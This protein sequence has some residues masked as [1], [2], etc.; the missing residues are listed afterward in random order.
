MPQPPTKILFLN[1]VSQMSGAEA[2]LLELVQALDPA[3]FAATVALPGPGPLADALAARG[4]PVPFLPLRRIH[5]TANPLTAAAS[6]WHLVRGA[7]ALR[8]LVRRDG[9][10]LVHANSNT[11]FLYAA[12]TPLPPDVRRVW[13]SRDLVPLGRPGS[14]LC[15]RA[16][17]V[18][19]NSDAVRQQLLAHTSD[20]RHIITI[21]NGIDVARFTPQG[22]RQRR[23][24]ELGVDN[25]APLIGM[26][27]QFVPWKRQD[28][29]L[30][31]AELLAAQLP[32]ARFV[33]VGAD[34]FSDHP[35]YA[36]ELSRRADSASLAGR[37]RILEPRPDIRPLYEALDILVHPAAR[38]PFG[39]VVAEA[40]AMGKPVVAINAAG[41]AEIIRDGVD[42]L[43]VPADSAPAL[44]ASVLRLV[45]NVALRQALG[46]AARQRICDA[47][48]LDRLA[49]TVM[50]L[51][52][53]LLS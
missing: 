24:A 29:F 21:H 26:V 13:H 37:V 18:V 3:R 36:R 10:R 39:R 22:E 50:A 7:A 49:G 33:L 11:A 35:A 27:G 4:V 9:F 2:S 20:P 40:M 16:D 23:R 44:A 32:T 34:L 12:F 48:S 31:M 8:R 25:D 17:R 42:G 15:R 38:E 47:F 43:L 46:T 41:P 14:W 53:D 6:A 30:D 28:L 52:A 5:R 45:G 51:Y 19:A 1:H